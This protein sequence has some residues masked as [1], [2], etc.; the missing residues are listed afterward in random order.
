MPTDPRPAAPDLH[1]HE[2]SYTDKSHSGP[3][4]CI[5][6]ATSWAGGMALTW[7]SAKGPENPTAAA[8]DPTLVRSAIEQWDREFGESYPPE[9]R[10]RVLEVPKRLGVYARV[11]H[12][13]IRPDNGICNQCGGHW[14]YRRD[15]SW[16]YIDGEHTPDCIFRRE[17][18]AMD[19]WKTERDPQ[20]T[21]EEVLG[22]TAPDVP[23]EEPSAEQVQ[24]WVA[25]LSDLALDPPAIYLP[26]HNLPES[27]D[28]TER[29]RPKRAAIGRLATALPLLIQRASDAEARATRLPACGCN[30]GHVT[31]TL[32]GCTREDCDCACEPGTMGAGAGISPLPT[33]RDYYKALA[34]ELDA[35][36]AELRDAEQRIAALQTERDEAGEKY[37]TLAL[38]VNDS[39][40]ECL[41]GCSKFGHEGDCPACDT[42]RWLS[43]QQKTITALQNRLARLTSERSAL[44]GKIEA[45]KRGALTTASLAAFDAV[46]ALLHTEE[47][48]T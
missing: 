12:E 9:A 18:G 19:S 14:T 3:C 41:P 17:A 16:E 22:A 20:G 6:G 1:K 24:E 8:P 5:C 31:P 28:I 43:D 35:Q 48:E 11:L 33:K 39:T 4:E 27:F 29:M 38:A 46:I 44:R 45:M 36:R 37:A 32:G 34:A 15:G 7:M 21:V 13:L 10:R 40:N 26:E 23:A 42:A 47:P 30:C 2:C 25:L